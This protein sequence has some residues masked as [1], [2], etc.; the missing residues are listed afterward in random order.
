MGPGPGMPAAAPSGGTVAYVPGSFAA[1]NNSVTVTLST[2]CTGG[3]WMIINVAN[4][5]SHTTAIA[6]TVSAGVAQT[7][8]SAGIQTGSAFAET[9]YISNCA[10]GSFTLQAQGNSYG[11]TVISIASY[12][13]LSAFDF[14]P[15][16]PVVSQAGTSGSVSC[17]ITTSNT[18]TIIGQILPNNGGYFDLSATWTV[19]SGW[20]LRSAA[21]GYAV[22]WGDDLS[23]SPGSYTYT[24]TYSSGSQ[25][26]T[27][28]FICML[29]AFK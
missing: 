1:A 6:V 27:T 10:A 29:A 12:T 17:S 23:A 5:Y 19:N 2:S 9:Y 7:I 14:A 25:S 20:T 11:Y 22:P 16:W 21:S 15:A 3:E 18:D 8:T 28:Q 4:F 13:G 26:T 24:G